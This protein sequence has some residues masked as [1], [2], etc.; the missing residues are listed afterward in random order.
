MDPGQEKVP[1]ANRGVALWG[2]LVISIANHPPRLIATNKETGEV[3]WQ[4]NLS[5]GQNALQFTAAPL[6]LRRGRL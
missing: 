2:N 1:D 3:V 5:D 6:A 4:T